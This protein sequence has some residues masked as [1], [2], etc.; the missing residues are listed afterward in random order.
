MS[1]PPSLVVRPWQPAGSRSRMPPPV[2]WPGLLDEAA[3]TVNQVS[4]A[5]TACRSGEP[6]RSCRWRWRCRHDRRLVQAWFEYPPR[7]HQNALHGRASVGSQPAVLLRLAK[8]PVQHHNAAWTERLDSPRPS[9]RSPDLRRPLLLGDPPA[10]RGR[11]QAA[12]HPPPRQL[13]VRRVVQVHP[14]TRSATPAPAWNGSAHL[15]IPPGRRDR[16]WLPPGCAA[17]W[18]AM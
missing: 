3:G 4:G 10:A 12:L 6:S 1:R 8:G 11:T 2:S 7:D 14:G 17:M 9:K 13:R 16:L 5:Q 15:G 18:L